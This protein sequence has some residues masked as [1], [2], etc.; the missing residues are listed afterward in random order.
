[1]H[2]RTALAVLAGLPLVALASR[3]GAASHGAVH[4]VTIKNFAFDPETLEVSPGDKVVFSNMDGAPHTATAQDKSWDT[5][6][7]AKGQSAEIAVTAGMTG[8]YVCRFH[9]SMKGR[10]KVTG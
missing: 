6:K 9:A 7:L 10:L 5:G 3:S 1:M 2:R 4:A 8:A